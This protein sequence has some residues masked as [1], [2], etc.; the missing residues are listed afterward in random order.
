MCETSK[1]SYF[2][3]KI[4]IYVDNGKDLLMT[5]WLIYPAIYPEFYPDP[6]THKSALK[7]AG[8]HREIR[9]ISR[10][11]RRISYADFRAISPEIYPDC[12]TFS[13]KSILMIYLI[14]FDLR[15][16]VVGG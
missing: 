15:E 16:I 11:I 10:E 9:R 7:S 6:C 5:W 14:S 8:F 2:E 13:L 12:L 1:Y 4:L 3:E